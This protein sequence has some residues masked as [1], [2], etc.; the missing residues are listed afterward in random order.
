MTGSSGSFDGSTNATTGI[1]VSVILPAHNE[2]ALLESVVTDMVIGLRRWGRPFEICIMENGSSDAT[3]IIGEGLSTAS[4]EVE[5]RTQP[6]ADY[7]MAVRRGL[8]DARGD[9]AVLF[10]V[11][12]YDLPFLEAA[13]SRLEDC[14][15][16]TCPVIVLGSKRAPGAHD[17]RP[18]RRRAVT[19]GFNL[20]L[21]R[22]FGLEVTDTHGM[23]A[24]D[25][26]R[27]RPIIAQ[28][29]LN[30]DLFDTELVI[31]AGRAGLP[32]AELPVTVRE[33][34]PPRSS[35]FKRAIRTV[36]GLRRLRTALRDP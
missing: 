26:R 5:L 11:D 36:G 7:G 13:V 22:G 34:R 19:A 9:I 24:L 29:E 28:C 25:L 16:G 10:D 33:Q 21:H 2:A 12:Y 3:A 31:R 17:E 23:K 6:V 14:A 8:L 1:A 15:E 32:V 27:V 35:L 20:I 30:A 4:P 18:L